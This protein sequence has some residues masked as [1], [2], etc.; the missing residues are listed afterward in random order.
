MAEFFGIATEMDKKNARWENRRHRIA[1]HMGKGTK[2]YM[3]VGTD[4]V[5]AAP[6]EIVDP[7]HRG[8]SRQMS[9]MSAM[10]GMST[11]GGPPRRK[12]SVL[13]MT[14]DGITNLSVIIHF[15]SLRLRI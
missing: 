4:S 14:V 7:L 9:R 15:F 11:A 10:S 13:K 2:Q 1:S 6:R 5:D 3:D 12:K 8:A